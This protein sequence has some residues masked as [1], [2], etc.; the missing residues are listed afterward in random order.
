MCDLHLEGSKQMKPRGM[1]MIGALVREA[2]GTG[3]MK[4]VTGYKCEASGEWIQFAGETKAWH[5]LP[6][7]EILSDGH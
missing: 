3:I 5:E 4:I 2:K 6:R 1:I 7:Y